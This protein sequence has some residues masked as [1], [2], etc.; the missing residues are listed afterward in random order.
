MSKDVDIDCKFKYF[1]KCNCVDF[2]FTQIDITDDR[3]CADRP[4]CHT[5][6]LR[7]KE[8]E[9]EK[10]KQALDEI[11]KYLDAQQQYFDGKDYHNLLDIIKKTKETN[12][13]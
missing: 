8:Q 4:N 11:E 12:N 6:R 10:Y 5:K 2:L 3:L 7:R 13:A 9:C 1:K